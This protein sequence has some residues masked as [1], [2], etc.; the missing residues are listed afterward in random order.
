MTNKRIKSG[1]RLR[2]VATAAGVSSAT[3]SAVVNGRAEQYGICPAT[4]EK[5]RAIVRQMGYSPSL[6]A[7][8]MAAGRNLLVGLA[9]AA[10][11]AG[12]SCLIT[13]LEPILA[14]AGFRLIVISLPSD[15]QIASERIISLI[16]FGVAGLVICPP[17]SLV[18]PK[19]T[20][21]AVIVGKSGAGLPAVIEDEPEGGRRLA[22]RLL[23]KGHRRIAILSGVTPGNQQPS[24][25]ATSSSFAMGGFLE[26]C[27]QAGATVR[28]FASVTEF[29]PLAGTVTAVF[30]IS[31]SVLL[32][33]YSRGLADG[34]RLGTNLAVVAVDGLGVAANLVPR[35]TV[36]H[37][38][39]AQLGQAAARVL[40]QAI[41]GTPSGNVRLDPVLVDGD[42]IST[43][44]ASSPQ[45]AAVPSVSPVTPKPPVSAPTPVPAKPV[46]VVPQTVVVPM[47]VSAPVPPQKPPILPSEALQ[48]PKPV[49][50]DAATP[51]LD[52]PKTPILETPDQGVQQPEK[53]EKIA[54]EPVS[55]SEPIPVDPVPA[56]SATE[57]AIPKVVPVNVPLEEPMAVPP[58]EPEPTHSEPAPTPAPEV[59]SSSPVFAG[60][61]EAIVDATPSQ[62]EPVFEPVAMPSPVS[63]VESEIIEP[64]PSSDTFLPDN[65]PPA[66]STTI[67]SPEPEPPEVEPV[68]VEPP[69]AAPVFEPAPVISPA[70]QEPSQVVVEPTPEPAPAP[71][72][73][74]TPTPVFMPAAVSEPVPIEP[75]PAPV[76][77]PV[78]EPEAESTPEPTSEPVPSPIPAFDLAA[79]NPALEQTPSR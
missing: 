36:L 38:G 10:D 16:Q 32:E 63:T 1:T 28:S 35:P 71:L 53:P 57:E 70:P 65:P 7:L 59:P 24:N 51:A 74:P 52:E 62:A 64:S 40:L 58:S 76:S 3:V 69:P 39:A 45:V 56:V 20:C 68:M 55:V 66:N 46:P 2:D 18:L 72:P 8:D 14:Q 54:P 75:D 73:I 50:P 26:A 42:K 25:S 9:V 31:S 43:P 27:A 5:V 13:A 79:S 67:S 37:P 61:A 12:R 23:D 22:R 34:Q 44:L 49:V 21:P 77:V 60:G 48:M 15:P 41:Q 17:D 30:C 33:L 19:I 29:L 6:A 78:S 4:Q 11:G 47:P